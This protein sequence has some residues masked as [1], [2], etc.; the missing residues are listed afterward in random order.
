MPKHKLITFVVAESSRAKRGGETLGMKETRSAPKYSES[1][2]PQRTKIGEAQ[3]AV[4]GDEVTF[5]IS[6]YSPTMIIAEAVR[7]VDDAFS[8]ATLALRDAMVD[9]AFEVVKKYGGKEQLAE[10]YSL[11][12]VT[13]YQGAPEQLAERGKVVAFLKAEKYPLDLKEIE[14]TLETSLKYSKD[15]LVIVDWDGACIFDPEGDDVESITDLFRIANVQL[16][17]YRA[18]DTELDNRIKRI[19]RYVR[20]APTTIFKR[21]EVDTAL[22]AVVDARAKSLNDF[23]TVERDIKLIGEWYS[24][25][26]YSL[27]T[28]K[29]RTEE[30]RA[31]VKEKLDSI[32][33]VYTIVA[34]NFRTS[35]LQFLELIQIAGFFILQA[36]WFVLIIFELFDVLKK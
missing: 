13:D 1:A 26:L 16:L 18:L 14:R 9:A 2:V 30:W 25:R 28:K 36:G 6:S 33:D 17:R 34:E 3:H 35:R 29:F 15:D 21:K 5:H 19:S 32:E 27:I 12:V 31:A 10:E 7:E 24:A 8:D 20:T 11:A 22:Q 4:G 23:E